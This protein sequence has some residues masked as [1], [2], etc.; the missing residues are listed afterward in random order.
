MFGEPLASLLSADAVEPAQI[1]GFNRIARGVYRFIPKGRC[2]QLVVISVGIHGN[3]TA[4]IE[5][6]NRWMMDAAT[7]QFNAEVL[8]IFANIPAMRAAERY[9][10]TNLNRLF[11]DPVKLGHGD[12][13]EHR[14]ARELMAL[15]D[16]HYQQFTELP[17]YHF[18]LH[19][20]IRKSLHPKFAVY[21]QPPAGVYRKR[22][23]AMLAAMGCEAVLL[24]DQPTSTFSCYSSRCGAM[25][26]TV[27]LGSVLPFGRNQL[28]SLKAVT[29]VLDELCQGG[30]VTSVDLPQLYQVVG[31]VNRQHRQFELHFAESLPNFSRF[32]ADEKLC[33]DGTQ[34]IYPQRA[35]DAVVFPN[36]N[37][38]IGQRA[39]LMVRPVPI[40]AIPTKN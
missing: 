19:T 24:S 27:E 25:A 17:R 16:S 34:A 18:D 23:L 8:V 11:T 39:M 28:S 14:R 5:L 6:V 2:T 21:P 22:L 30:A 15:I 20:A 33:T 4:P 7:A 3:E 12:T 37:V 31:T 40:S 13:A 35:G 10:D 32:S 38:E 9:I 29:T 26:A 1:N 36:A